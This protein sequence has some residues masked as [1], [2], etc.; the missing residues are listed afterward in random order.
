MVATMPAL[1][2]SLA[3]PHPTLKIALTPTRES[4]A[5]AAIAGLNHPKVYSNLN[6]PP[7]PYTEKDWSEWYAPIASASSDNLAELKAIQ[8]QTPPVLASPDWSKKR[9]LGQRPWTST[10]RT[11]VDGRFIGNIGVQRESSHI[12]ATPRR[13]N[14]G[15]TKTTC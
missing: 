3:V 2:F 10:I 4:D 14:A 5:D 1:D 8:E 13:G 15:R 7:Y 12:F 9:W 11:V 6:G